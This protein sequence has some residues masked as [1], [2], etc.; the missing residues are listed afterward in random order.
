MVRTRSGNIPCV[1]LKK[2]KKKKKAH[3]LTIDMIRHNGDHEYHKCT[4]CSQKLH[5]KSNWNDWLQCP[6]CKDVYHSQCLFKWCLR[7]PNPSCPKCRL[8]IPF[9][10]ED[11]S[12]IEEEWSLK[13]DADVSDESESESDME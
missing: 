7:S 2:I 9:N 4:C 10:F 11:T 3:F 13:F 1:V 8:S 12:N 6:Q 5:L